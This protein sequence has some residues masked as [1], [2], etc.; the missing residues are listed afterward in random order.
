MLDLSG[1]KSLT[2]LPPKIGNLKELT[3]LDLHNCSSLTTLFDVEEDA[4]FYKFLK[5]GD[6]GQSKRRQGQFPK[7]KKLFLS[8]CRN[9]TKLR[10]PEVEMLLHLEELDLSDCS[11]LATL[12]PLIGMLQNLEK[13]E[14]SYCK[15]L[16]ELPFSLLQLNKLEYLALRGSA[17]PAFHV[18]V[19]D[20]EEKKWV[21]HWEDYLAGCGITLPVGAEECW[22]VSSDDIVMKRAKNARSEE[23]ARSENFS[24]SDQFMLVSLDFSG[25]LDFSNSSLSHLP[26]PFHELHKLEALDKSNN[27]NI[28][29]VPEDLWECRNLEKV[30]MKDCEYSAKL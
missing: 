8:G 7:L 30:I 18:L 1:C 14:L 16:K 22:V 2:T 15:D 6:D 27:D 17:V 10:S 21:E 4:L 3:E 9:L 24:R 20:D 5:Q 26:V 29:E 28:K 13:L 11:I 25:T 23:A 12:S 19:R